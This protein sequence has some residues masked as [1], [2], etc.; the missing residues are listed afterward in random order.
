MLPFQTQPRWFS[1]MET[2][3]LFAS[4]P[5]PHC[6]KEHE[7]PGSSH[8]NWADNPRH[9][10]SSS[11]A[12]CGLSRALRGIS[13]KIERSRQTKWG[14]ISQRVHVPADETGVWT[15]EIAN[16]D[17]KFEVGWQKACALCLYRTGCRNAVQRVAKQ[18]CESPDW[19]WRYVAKSWR[20]VARQARGAAREGGVLL[21]YVDWLSGE[22]ACRSRLSAIAAEASM[23]IRG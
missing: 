17:I 14:S 6:G 13:G 9:P 2:V 5:V 20:G 18:A 10:W 8:A 3:S 16:C 19:A 4:N 22:P 23:R 1:V 21:Q 7:R 12:G 15:L 11:H